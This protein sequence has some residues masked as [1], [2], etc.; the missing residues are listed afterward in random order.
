MDVPEGLKRDSALAVLLGQLAEVECQVERTQLAE[1]ERDHVRKQQPLHECR[2]FMFLREGP[3]PPGDCGSKEQPNCRTEYAAR[4]LRD[5]VAQRYG[6]VGKECLRELDS[7][8][9]DERASDRE[10]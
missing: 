8:T 1:D 6:S 7:R 10:H 9:E 5:H 2:P 3:Q 4:C